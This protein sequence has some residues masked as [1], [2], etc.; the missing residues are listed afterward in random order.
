MQGKEI[1]KV[2]QQLNMK[3]NIF[4]GRLGISK[5]YLSKIEN[6]EQ[7]CKKYSGLTPKQLF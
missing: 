3:Q 2:R 5:S 1:K 7:V 4:A 6:N